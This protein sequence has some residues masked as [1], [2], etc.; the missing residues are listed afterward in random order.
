MAEPGFESRSIRRP[1]KYCNH[2][3]TEADSHLT[4]HILLLSL[5]FITSTALSFCLSGLLFQKL[6]QDRLGPPWGLLERVS[7]SYRPDALSVTEPT[8]TKQ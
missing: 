7:L 3:A 2:L 5:M 1:S 6:L 8:V 4:V